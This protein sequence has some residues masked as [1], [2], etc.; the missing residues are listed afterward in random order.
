MVVLRLARSVLGLQVYME[1]MMLP[2]TALGGGS[3]CEIV[4][5]PE[6]SV[7]EFSQCE[8]THHI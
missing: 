7:G 8:M 4:Y 3:F 6:V 2:A 1:N 5:Q